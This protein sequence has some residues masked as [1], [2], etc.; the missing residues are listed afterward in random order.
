[1][2][3][4][5]VILRTDSNML[6][7][8]ILLPAKYIIHVPQGLILGPLLFILYI[9]DIVNISNV[10]SLIMFADDT[11]IFLCSDSLQGL[12]SYHL[13]FVLFSVKFH[14]CFQ[15]RSIKVITMDVKEF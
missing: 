3:D 13:P 4:L 6:K 1:M 11:N 7:L 9:N 15:F 8:V 10:A 14:K 5:Q 2:I 12:E